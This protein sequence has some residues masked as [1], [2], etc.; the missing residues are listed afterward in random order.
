MAAAVSMATAAATPPLEARADPMCG[1][2]PYKTNAVCILPYSGIL[3]LCFLADVLCFK[4]IPAT[5]SRGMPSAPSLVK[6]HTK[7]ADGDLVL[8]ASA[9]SSTSVSK[10]SYATGPPHSGV[11]K[12]A[13]I[14]SSITVKRTFCIQ[15]NMDFLEGGYGVNWLWIGLWIYGT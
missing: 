14:Q 9:Q 15:F 4:S 3:I 5:R 2:Q 1:T 8:P 7:H 6:L 10:D 12:I 11:V 13:T